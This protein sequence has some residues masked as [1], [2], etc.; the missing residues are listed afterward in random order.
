MRTRGRARWHHW[1]HELPASQELCQDVGFPASKSQKASR[2]F[3]PRS[4]DSESRV[5]TVTPRGRGARFCHSCAANA[6]HAGARR[7]PTTTG[8]A[9]ACDVCN[10]RRVCNFCRACNVR[11]ACKVCSVCYICGVGA[12][13]Y[14]RAHACTYVRGHGRMYIYCDSA[15]QEKNTTAK[16]TGA[17]VWKAGVG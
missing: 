12:R 16:P 2:G 17:C 7:E 14:A 4:L 11:R 13:V 15:G 5:L 8:A 9:I 3:E 1:S 6:K 10:I